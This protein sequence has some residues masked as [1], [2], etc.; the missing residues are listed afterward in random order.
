MEIKPLSQWLNSSQKP[1]IISGPCSAES[2][3]QLLNTAKS[4]A[5]SGKTHMLR[6]GIWKPRTRPNSFEGNG[7]VALDWLREAGEITGLP[8]SCEVANAQHVE[9]S[10]K[11]GINALW[12]GARTTVS[13]FAVQEIAD[14][15][16]GH[17]IPVMVKNPVNPDIHLW[18][19]AL[20]R[21]NRAG[22]TQLAAIH[23]G[24]STS[25]KSKFRNV[26]M[27]EFPI[28]LKIKVPDL[29]IFCDPSHISGNRKLILE[30]SQKAM[31]LNMAGLMIESHE[32]PEEAWS[33][34]SQQ[35]S[36]E[37]LEEVLQR[38]VIRQID[39]NEDFKNHLAELRLQIDAIDEQI[40]QKIS[41]RMQLAEKIGEYKKENNVTILQIKRWEEIIKD[42]TLLGESTGLSEE[43]MNAMLQ[44]IHQ[45]SI[46]IQ[47]KVMNSD[48]NDLPLEK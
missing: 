10:L 18:I 15:L 5:A 16:K 30:I 14:A 41:S 9:E 24:F 6:A 21:L 43:F 11:A 3:E 8:T 12:I 44:L 40:I 33:D 45:E 37:E 22:I 25:G 23:R 20:E 35:I 34:S 47:T 48:T 46:R 2:R 32:K 42:R 29:P 17:D 36:P 4:L 27:W 28:E 26:P 39:G 1:Y 13:P 7:K 38:L 31:D 19:G